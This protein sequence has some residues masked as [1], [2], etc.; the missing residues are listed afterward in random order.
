MEFVQPIGFNR[1]VV[2]YVVAP[3]LDPTAVTQLVGVTPEKAEAPRWTL[4]HRSDGSTGNYRASGYWAHG[5][6]GK[7][8]DPIDVIVDQAIQW[9]MVHHDA[10]KRLYSDC[11]FVIAF[12]YPG[13]QPSD[14]VL[15]YREVTDR[16]G[17]EL[18]SPLPR[19]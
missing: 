8:T 19:G 15:D 16:L 2:V 6:R 12:P 10:L 1:G 7:P 5:V 14:L 13:L 4:T 3:S 9:I 17:I 11:R 18:R